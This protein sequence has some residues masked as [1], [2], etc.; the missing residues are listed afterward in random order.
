VRWGEWLGP[1]G[2]LLAVAM[3]LG[4]SGRPRA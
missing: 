2:V 3:L 1:A 4:T